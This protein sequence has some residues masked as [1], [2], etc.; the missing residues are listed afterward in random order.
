MYTILGADGKEYGPVSADD[1]RQWMTEGRANSDTNVRLEGTTAW[2]RIADLPEFAAS[3]E[4][5]AAPGVS[6]TG[7]RANADAVAAPAIGLMVTAAIGFV[8]QLLGLFM[9]RLFVPSGIDGESQGLSTLL[10][11]SFGSPV[12]IVSLGA[13]GVI[14][15]GALKMKKRES[16]EWAMGAS[17]LALVPFLSPCCLIGLPIGIWSLVIL[18]KPEVKQSFT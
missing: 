1:V 16:R 4:R 9:G 10:T 2:K 5:P 12:S 17:V 15:Y 13:A 7:M 18:S 3:R 8:L 6:P 14:F 11:G